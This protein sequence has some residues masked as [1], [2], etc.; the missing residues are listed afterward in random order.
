MSRRRSLNPTKAISIT[1]PIALLEEI[2]D[3]LTRVDSRS[4]WIAGACEQRLGNKG[5]VVNDATDLQLLTALYN[6]DVIMIGT[7]NAIR[8]QIKK[9]DRFTS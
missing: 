3:R 6:R 9:R 8:D 5:T 1:L 4:K 2:D 7:F